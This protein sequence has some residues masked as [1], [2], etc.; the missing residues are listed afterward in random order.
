MRRDR[1]FG[2]CGIV[3]IIATA[4]ADMLIEMVL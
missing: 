3:A 4:C 2:L 1:L